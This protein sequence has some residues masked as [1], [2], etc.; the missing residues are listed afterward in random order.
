M[1]CHWYNRNFI[2]FPP[3]A[4]NRNSVRGSNQGIP[5]WE[6]GN[7][8]L[9]CIQISLPLFYLF[10]WIMRLLAFE[11]REGHPLFWYKTLTLVKEEQASKKLIPLSSH[12]HRHFSYW[13][14]KNVPL[15]PFTQK[16]DSLYIPVSLAEAK[17]CYYLLLFYFI[18][19]NR[20]GWCI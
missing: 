13:F 17:L 19:C 18:I 7:G 5:W 2:I 10:F 11:W 20:F 1:T 15:Y 4:Y 12:Y 16:S 8:N 9:L 6:W 14:F 3:R